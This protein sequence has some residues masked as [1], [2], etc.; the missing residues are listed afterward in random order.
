[1]PGATSQA[2]KTL[3]NRLSA[4]YG[5]ADLFYRAFDRWL[6]SVGHNCYLLFATY[7]TFSFGSTY[8][9]A[10]LTHKNR[11]FWGQPSWVVGHGFVAPLFAVLALYYCRRLPELYNGIFKMADVSARPQLW[12]TVTQKLRTRLQG[13]LNWQIPAVVIPSAALL[14]LLG[15]WREE[16][17]KGVPALLR[18]ELSWAAFVYLRLT[19]AVNFYVIFSTALRLSLISEAVCQLLSPGLRLQYDNPDGSG[20]TRPVGDLWLQMWV[21]VLLSTAYLFGYVHPAF[22]A[23]IQH[24]QVASVILAAVFVRFLLGPLTAP[25][26][27][28]H[29]AMVDFRSSM[30]DVLRTKGTRHCWKELHW[31]YTSVPHPPRETDE[32]SA[33]QQIVAHLPVW[34]KWVRLTIAVSGPLILGVLLT[35]VQEIV[36]WLI[37]RL[38]P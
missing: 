18:G 17:W 8:L 20:G 6:P 25:M 22:G 34:P 14:A 15:V 28:T 29:R 12:A 27:A 30:F 37:R 2:T 26:Y 3:Q 38:F 9:V 16:S 32:F 4:I 36:K 5:P 31:H 19:V 35:V 1:M 11:E 10:A 13:R 21:T 33:C 23:G 7:F 24:S